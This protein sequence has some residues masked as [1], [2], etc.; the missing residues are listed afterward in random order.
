MASVILHHPGRSGSP[1]QMC[2]AGS[3]FGAVCRSR[4]P[5]GGFMAFMNRSLPA[6]NRPL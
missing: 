2:F 6:I 5:S 3:T 4:G 1:G